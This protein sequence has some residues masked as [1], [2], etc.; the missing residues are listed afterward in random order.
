MDGVVAIAPD[1]DA[2]LIDL[3]A[4]RS[5]PMA[6][7]S[8]SPRASA[9]FLACDNESGIAQALDHLVGLGHRRIGMVH[10]ELSFHDGAARYRTFQA[11]LKDK[12]LLARRDWLTGGHF[13]P[14]AGYDAGKRMLSSSDRPTAILAGNDEIARSLVQAAQELGLSVPSD[15]SV[16]GFDDTLLA[17]LSSPALTTVSQ[18]LEGLGGAA[19]RAVEA[20]LQKQPTPSISTFPTT[21]IVR[22]STGSPKKDLS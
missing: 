13:T 16:V 6:V 21:L 1:K 5:F 22:A 8:G 18:P 3:L 7:V 12:G 4:A 2:Q 17:R 20:I 11:Y 14:A 19:V 9:P 15:V 10:G